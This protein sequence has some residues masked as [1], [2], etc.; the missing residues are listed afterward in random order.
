MIQLNQM[1]GCLEIDSFKIHPGFTLKEVKALF[2]VV[3]IEKII[4]NGNYVS[5]GIKGVDDF[6]TAIS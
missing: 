1:D 4:E 3:D 5:F 6:C 2:G